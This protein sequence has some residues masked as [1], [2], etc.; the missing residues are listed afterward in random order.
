MSYF[1]EKDKENLKAVFSDNQGKKG[2]PT[3]YAPNFQDILINKLAIPE[4]KPAESPYKVKSGA[5]GNAIKWGALAFA[6]GT[7]AMY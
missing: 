1:N 3:K 6:A 4:D 5:T 2:K 7:Y